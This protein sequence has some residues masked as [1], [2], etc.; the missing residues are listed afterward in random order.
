MKFYVQGTFE[1]LTVTFD[2]STM[3]RTQFQLWYSR[4][5][6]GREMS[7]AMFVLIA[8]QHQQSKKTLKQWRRWFW[9]MVEPLLESLLIMLAYVKLMPSNY[10][11][12]FRHETCGSE[13]CFKIAKFWAKKKPR[14]DI[15]Q[16]RWWWIMGAW[17]WD[18]TLKP[19]PNHPVLL[20][21][22]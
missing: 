2:K 17:F 20:L 11:G 18:M 10:Y 3:S 16:E 21:L 15:T 12:C 13:D 5:K 8:L 1:M 22:K 7:T 19:K 9:I 4:F 6:E 14:M